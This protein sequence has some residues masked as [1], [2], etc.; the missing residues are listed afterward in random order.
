MP[1]RIVLAGAILA[2]VLAACNSNANNPYAYTTASPGPTPTYSANPTI[3][4][5]TVT[6]YY[7]SFYQAGAV[8]YETTDVNGNIGT[9][10]TNQTANA[11]GSTTFTGLKPG[12]GYC[13]YFIYG[14]GNT[15]PTASACTVQWDNGINLN[16]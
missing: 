7:R 1:K 10:I 12:I 8:I 13:W 11:S 2:L 6:A 9:P 15:K 3:T 14:S 5:T 16:G 4:S